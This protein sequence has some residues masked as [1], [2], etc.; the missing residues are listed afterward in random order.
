MADEQAAQTAFTA[1]DIITRAYRI[2]GDLG[3][4]EALTADQASD[5]LEGL[6]ALLD[7]QTLQKGM[8]FQIRQ[9]D[10]T[11][12]AS[13]T[14]RTIGSSGDFDTHRPDLVSPGTYFTDSNNIAY[15]PT[16]T[17]DRAV[18]DKIEDK[19]T[20]SSY[21]E[22]LFYERSNPLGTL[23]VYPVPA[24]SLTL[25]LNQGQPLQVFDT[26]TEA[27]AAP[28]GY[29]RMLPFVLA[30][31]MEAEVGLPMPQNAKNIAREAKRTLAR[32]NNLPTISSTEVFHVLRG[33]RRSDIVAGR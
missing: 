17:H 1:N 21:P 10:L 9:E 2:L 8:I 20:S 14:S 18:Y 5:G 22:L 19:T 33:G 29:R 11:W 6:N 12:P 24:N 3:R 13:T 16:I 26:L 28:P 4:G 7:S 25:K 31:E 15:T 23:F 27:L 32:H 30:L